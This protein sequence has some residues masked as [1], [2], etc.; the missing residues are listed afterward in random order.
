MSCISQLLLTRFAIW[1]TAASSLHVERHLSRASSPWIGLDED[2][3]SD[4]HR[5]ILQIAGMYDSGSNLLESL[6]DANIP[7]GTFRKSLFGKHRSPPRLAALLNEQATVLDGSRVVVAAIVRSP[8]AQIAGWIKAPY[9]FRSQI[10]DMDLLHDQRTLLTIPRNGGTFQGFTGLW[11]GFTKGYAEFDKHP[12]R[13][14]VIVEYERLV[15]D[16]EAVIHEVADALG[17]TLAGD[18]QVMEEPAK[19]HGHPKGRELALEEI[20]NM[21]YLQKPPLSDASVRR[22]L[23]EKLDAA[24]LNLHIIPVPNGRRSYADDCAFASS[25]QSK[26]I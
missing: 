19:E 7:K 1:I 15:Y 9:D 6:I 22:A 20:V 25:S 10:E 8:L 5:P 11:N 14:V 16:P 24:T 21:T 4:D 18:F 12:N 26:R 17:T 13:S 3:E 2:F 23:C